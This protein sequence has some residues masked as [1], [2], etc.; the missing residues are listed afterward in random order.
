MSNCILTVDQTARS[1]FDRCTHLIELAP[2]VRV[3]YIDDIDQTLMGG[4]DYTRGTFWKNVYKCWTI[5]KWNWW[6]GS[7]RAYIINFYKRV[8]KWSALPV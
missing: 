7:H 8:G 6:Q 4:N 5:R 2:L 3:E 1:D